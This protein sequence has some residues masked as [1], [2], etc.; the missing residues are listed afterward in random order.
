VFAKHNTAAQLLW[1]GH[2]NRMPTAVGF[3]LTGRPDGYEREEREAA[4]SVNS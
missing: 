2:V 4:Q 1:F 3:R